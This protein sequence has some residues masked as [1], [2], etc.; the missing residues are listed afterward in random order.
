MKENPTIH[1]MHS[2][3]PTLAARDM[4]YVIDACVD[5]VRERKNQ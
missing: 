5:M 4:R 1:A 2:F 3:D